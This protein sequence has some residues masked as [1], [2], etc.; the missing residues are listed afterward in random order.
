VV[1]FD[2][3]RLFGNTWNSLRKRHSDADEAHWRL[4]QYL[5]P[6]VFRAGDYWMVRSERVRV[7][8]QYRERGPWSLHGIAVGGPFMHGHKLSI[9]DVFDGKGI[10]YWDGKRVSNPNSFDFG[11]VVDLSISRSGGDFESMEVSLLEGVSLTIEGLFCTIT[12]R[13]QPGGQDGH[14]GKADGDLMDDTKDF[15]LASDP[16]VQPEESLF[17][18]H[19][20]DFSLVQGA[21]G[22]AA[23][24]AEAPPEE[25]LTACR[26][27]LVHAGFDAV[28]GEPYIRSCAID[29]CAAPDA[30]AAQRMLN[31]VQRVA[32]IT[33]DHA[34]RADGE[35][36][37]LPK[38]RRAIDPSD[39]PHGH[40]R[41]TCLEVAGAQPLNGSLVQTQDCDADTPALG[42]HFLLPE[43][44]TGFIRWAGHSNMCLDVAQGLAENGNRIQIWRC[45][46]GHPNMQF[47]M[48]TDGR[49]KIQWAGVEHPK[50]CLDVTQGYSAPGTPIQLW[51]C[52][53]GPQANQEFLVG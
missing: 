19:L 16:A 23:Q 8:G 37:N 4:G 53:P 34:E 12:M 7:Q 35:P 38:I 10:V 5:I 2:L 32:S 27:A 20:R 41:Q 50:M 29:V 24:C 17:S 9:E 25:D 22:V 30:A 49:G 18:Q 43:S 42:R 39:A 14:C 48:P 33:A 46:E 11:G 13:K 6:D 15:L 44:G 45:K 21:G 40:G 47:I 28:F 52:Q 3:F 51:E 36:T 26:T 1:T 31:L